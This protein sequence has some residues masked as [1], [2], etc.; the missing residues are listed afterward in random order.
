MVKEITSLQHPIV[1]HLVKLRENKDY[2]YQNQQV[3]LSGT[4]LIKELGSKLSFE[5]LMVE[6]GWE[7]KLKIQANEIF[8]VPSHVLKKIAGVASCEPFAAVI[9]MPK[10]PLFKSISSL[11]IL[12]RVSDPG[13]LGTLLRSAFA[14]GWEGAF[15]I[16]GTTDPY[17]E[18]AIRAA[19]GAN[20]YLPWKTGSIKELEQ[21]LHQE[22]LSLF[23]ADMG[24]K[25]FTDVV[26]PKKIALALGN[27]SHGLN[28]TIKERAELIAISMKK[29]MESLNVAS[30][31]A[32]LLW[33][34]KRW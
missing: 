21:L 18:K 14:F 34:T 10:F 25:E 32:I 16:E 30:A 5:M 24:G 3:F 13:N 6:K 4:K 17:H 15:L 33:G 29:E 23:G 11:L 2:R 8:I 22:Q 28:E 26:F 1:K 20:F 19:K 12:D 31:G 9:E 7:K 27:E